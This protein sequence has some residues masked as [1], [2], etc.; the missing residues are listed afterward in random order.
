MPV[1]LSPI[2]CTAKRKGR[3][4]V[5]T[6]RGQ[7]CPRHSIFIGHSRQVLCYT[8]A[9]SGN[10][11][12]SQNFPRLMRIM[13]SNYLRPAC[14]LT[15]LLVG[16]PFLSAADHP[17]TIAANDNRSPAGEVRNGV[18]TIHLEIG[19]GQWHP[20]SESGDAL[21]V[22]AFG[23]TGH[24]LQNPGP[25]IRVPQGTEIHAFVHNAL[26]VTATV[27][28]LHERP[29][30]EKEAIVLQPGAMQE[31]RFKAG[32]PGTYY[33]W[34]T[35]TGSPIGRRT[36]I[37]T[38]L[39]GAFIVDPSGAAATDRI[40]VIGVWYK[41]AQFRIG[42]R[43]QLATVN[44]KSWPYAERLTFQVGESVHWRWLNPSVSEHSMH[45][46][47]FYYQVDG[48]GDGEHY[49][50]SETER[51]LIVTHLVETGETFDMTW[52][53]ERA[54]R[55]LFHCH[56]LI[57]MSPS[58]WQVPS[59]AAV[60][61]AAAQEHHHREEAGHSGMGGLVLGITVLDDKA[62]SQA[63]AWHAERK[64][65]LTINERTDGVRPLYRL[66]VRDPAAPDVTQASAASPATAQLIGPP[67][68]LT[69][70]QSTEIEVLNRSRQPTAIHW[71]GIELE[72]YYDGVAGWTGT[73]QQTTPPIQPGASF[74]ARMTPPR[75]GTF[76]YH[77]HWHD[78]AQLENGMYGPLIVLPPGQK[79]DPGT[80]KTFLFS[81]GAFEPFGSILLI[82]GHPQPPLLRLATG[83]KYRFRL[84]NIAPN[85]ARMRAS[86]RRAGTP[87]EWRIVAKDGADL[88][89]SLATTQPANLGITVGETYDF[90]YQANSPEDLMLEV[91]QPGQKK[92]ITQGFVFAAERVA[93]QNDSS[94]QTPGR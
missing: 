71:H 8:P 39:A 59:T 93:N 77:T 22:Y 1:S 47:G 68:V 24:P 31:V 69:Q 70:G 83:T 82:N 61:T 5:K 44:G 62:H 9:D 10:T 11:P 55:W 90:E 21:T 43:P 76:I 3:T 26:H 16:T 17:A 86:L 46:H 64:L 33:Y 85:Q 34:A 53:P 36:P 73:T 52:V 25:L 89:A 49:G 37:E 40:F 14:L 58:E 15:M 13:I 84:I 79:Y 19:E 4:S 2:D 91:L 92:Q 60:A 87:V 42:T 41:E 18:L 72:S 88:P 32:A 74:I 48:G 7:E 57:H 67:I 35:T 63:P 23:E 56:M 12:D 20:E 78:Q 38:Q 51:P 81:M 66:D 6:R 94:V 28:G 45:L 30:S 50:Y 80:D 75:A 65:Q 27:H 54:G 29:G